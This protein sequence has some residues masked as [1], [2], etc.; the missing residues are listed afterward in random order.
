MKA[1]RASS[2]S[3][4]WL[5]ILPVVFF[6]HCGRS[7]SFSLS[8]LH[9]FAKPFNKSYGT[10]V[11]HVRTS[12][13]PSSQKRKSLLCPEFLL[14]TPKLLSSSSVRSTHHSLD[15]AILERRTLD[16]PLVRRC[17]HSDP[18]D[19]TELTPPWCSVQHF[20]ERSLVCPLPSFDTPATDLAG[21]S[22]T[23]TRP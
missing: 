8:F 19:L 11:I 15:P 10:S 16:P 7:S 21:H 17:A 4:N 2:S 1:F 20:A 6:V 13:V 18:K 22:P 5:Q 3:R 14:G 12:T 23:S 9:A